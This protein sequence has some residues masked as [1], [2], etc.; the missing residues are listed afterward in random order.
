M[1]KVVSARLQDGTFQRLS[2]VA[3]ILD[4][5]PSDTVAT[6]VEESLRAIEFALIEFRSSPLGRQAFMQGSSLAVWEVIE[7]SQQY[8]MNEEKVA[9]HFER[10]PEWVK[11]AFNYAEAYPKEIDFAIQDSQAVTLTDLK[12]RLPNLEVFSVD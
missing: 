2:R 7:I 4:K 3:R 11:A 5:T 9:E 1:S 8:Q 6:L 12:R 10:S